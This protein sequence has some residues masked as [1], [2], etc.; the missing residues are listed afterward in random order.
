MQS[1]FVRNCYRA[2]YEFFYLF[3]PMRRRILTWSQWWRLKWKMIDSKI[4]S[5]I[6]FEAPIFHILS[7]VHMQR[8]NK[9]RQR[10]RTS[11]QKKK[12]RSTLFR[13]ET[14]SA[15]VQA[16]TS[17]QSRELTGNPSP[18]ISPVMSCLAFPKS[19]TFLHVPMNFIYRRATENKYKIPIK[20]NET[21][22]DEGEG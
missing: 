22:M 9:T 14:R 20:W 13:S 17:V 19:R 8:H 5:Q 1:C 12:T 21:L 18:P 16:E 10:R 7:P 6:I 3:W 15:S 11:G 2:R 4:S